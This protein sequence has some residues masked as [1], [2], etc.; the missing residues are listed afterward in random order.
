VNT[1]DFDLNLL[2]VLDA[3]LREG[4]VTRAS[5]TLHL[6]QPAMSNALNRLREQLNDSIVVRVGNRMVPTPRALL[7]AEPV[8]ESLRLIEQT[9]QS[10][11]PFN[12]ATASA[13]VR[14]MATDYVSA[15][16]LPALSQRLRK[17]SPG[18][19]LAI[20]SPSEVGSSVML[21]EGKVDI[22]LAGPSAELQDTLKQQKLLD[23]EFVCIARRR[24][25]ALKKGL[26]LDAYCA[27]DHILAS[28]RGG[29]FSSPLDE[30]LAAL[31]RKRKVCLS[32]AQ[33]LLGPRLVAQSD[34]LMTIGK[35]LAQS[36]AQE[37]D[38]TIYPLP[39]KSPGFRIVQAWHVRLDR[40][41]LQKWLRTQ[42]HEIAEQLQ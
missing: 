9:L 16:L 31:G 17:S 23:E 24:H 29:G 20:L 8:R 2:R 39:F 12:P 22:A 34:M 36:F 15:V 32:I 30:T 13:Q 25:P 21:S 1:Q 11:Q 37:L 19:E 42:I 41:P 7:L 35:R 40:D 18:I 38:V 10:S 27:A 14:L 28:P 3:I 6:S 26:T 33:F 4:S 5:Q